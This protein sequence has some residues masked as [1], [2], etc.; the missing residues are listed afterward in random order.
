MQ[1]ENSLLG[2]IEVAGRGALV[3]NSQASYKK[4]KNSDTAELDGNGAFVS[5]VPGKKVPF[6]SRSGAVTVS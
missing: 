3:A 5:A 2:K 1:T 6:C 4:N